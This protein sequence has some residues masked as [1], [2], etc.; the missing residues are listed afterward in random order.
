[1]LKHFFPREKLGAISDP[2]FPFVSPI[3]HILSPTY[4]S[5]AC[6]FHFATVTNGVFVY[7]QSSNIK[8]LTL[9]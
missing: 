8:I 3:L 6:L 4:I 9:P 1:M 7:P 5:Q 2:L